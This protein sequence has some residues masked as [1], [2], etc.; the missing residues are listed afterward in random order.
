ML[1]TVF[2]AMAS[3]L[4]S[5]V[6]ELGL[7][8]PDAHDLIWAQYRKVGCVPRVERVSDLVLHG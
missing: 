5:L 1:I 8:L 3:S 7:A 4:T 6:W 2:L